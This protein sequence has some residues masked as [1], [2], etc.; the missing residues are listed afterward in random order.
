MKLYSLTI[1]NFRSY[2]EAV[3]VYFD[4]FTAFVGK[5]NEGKSNLLMAIKV[6]ITTL[7][8]YVNMRMRKRHGNYFNN[9][10]AFM[11]NQYNRDEGNNG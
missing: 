6:A 1:K 9:E 2:R 7:Q 5:N 11:L 10:F 3:T 4:N 8:E